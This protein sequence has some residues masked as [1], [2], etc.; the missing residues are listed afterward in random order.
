M[1]LWTAR[2]RSTGH[3]RFHERRRRRVET[4]RDTGQLNV[5]TKLP[6]NRMLVALSTAHYHHHILQYRLVNFISARLNSSTLPMS[7]TGRLSTLKARQHHNL[8]R[9]TR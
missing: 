8:I 4:D 1:S 5:L 2:P 9:A 6:V 7:I 3:E